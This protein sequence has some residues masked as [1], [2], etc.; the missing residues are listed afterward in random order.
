MPR[1]CAKATASQ[2]RTITSSAL[3]RT[4]LGS[5]RARARASAASELPSSTFIV[6]QVDFF[7]SSDSA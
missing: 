3:K 1:A 5:C 6:K 2:T 7:F 4:S